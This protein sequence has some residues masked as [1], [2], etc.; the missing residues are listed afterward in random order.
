M[1]LKFVSACQLQHVGLPHSSLF[2]SF[3]FLRRKMANGMQMI[4]PPPLC[5]VFM[6]DRS[7]M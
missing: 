6:G 4:L 3:L 5:V 1:T 2:C 7:T